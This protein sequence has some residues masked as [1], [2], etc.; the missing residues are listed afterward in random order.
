MPSWYSRQQA[1][2]YLGVAEWELAE[3]SIEYV[4][5]ALVAMDAESRA[6][7]DRYDRLKPQT[8]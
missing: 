4:N 5:R 8:G 6:A 7:Q 3:H 2:R 1:A